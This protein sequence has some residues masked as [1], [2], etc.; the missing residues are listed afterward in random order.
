MH[1]IYFVSRLALSSNFVPFWLNSFFC[2]LFSCFFEFFWEKFKN[3]FR[4]KKKRFSCYC[5]SDLVGRWAHFENLF[6]VF[7]K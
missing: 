3:F 6:A 5:G 4:I 7:F 1:L 2:F